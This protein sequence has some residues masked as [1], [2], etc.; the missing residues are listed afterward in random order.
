M[1]TV[2]IAGVPVFAVAAADNDNRAPEGSMFKT[3]LIVVV[4]L[5]AALLIYAATKPDTFRVQRSTSI[6]A[7]PEKIFPLINDFHNF[8]VWSP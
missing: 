4:V 2:S 8:G 1:L 6:N 3:I 7:A 5:L